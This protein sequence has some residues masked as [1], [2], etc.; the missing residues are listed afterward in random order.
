MTEH[1]SKNR[2]TGMTLVEL[3]VAMLIGSVLIGGVLQ[4]FTNTKQT[5]VIQESL[6]RLQ[7]NGRFAMNFI[8]RDIRMADYWGCFATGV[9]GINNNLDFA[10]N[11]AAF[12]YSLGA[13]TGVQ[14]T[15][16]GNSAL[17]AA[18]S[19]TIRGASGSGVFLTSASVDE[20]AA[21]TVAAHDF[22]ANDLIFV[23]DCN[24]ADIFQ[25][26]GV[27]A[28]TL[29]HT[30]TGTPGNTTVSLS[31]I[32]G[33]DAQLYNVSTIKYSIQMGEGG[34]PALFKKNNAD[35]AV[36]LLEGVENMQIL[37][38][39][40]TN[41]DKTPDYYVS[42]NNVL[43]K[44]NIVS[45]NITLLVVSAEDNLASQPLAYTYNGATTTPNDRRIRRVFSSTIAVRNRL[46]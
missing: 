24:K 23:T 26:S 20:I 25:A 7:E 8:N 3:L 1:T 12:N 33:L 35:A 39:E 29:L 28:N 6:S 37:Y 30:L 19:I 11:P 17:D 27:T 34:R 2:Q 22:D 42:W 32:Y 14:G 9:G 44:N 43:V 15:V 46:P 13:I 41:N 16:A 5:Y 38:G 45:L 40:D 10:S 31:D 4:V 21:L 36:E 18:D